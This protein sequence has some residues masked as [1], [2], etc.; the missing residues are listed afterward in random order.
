MRSGEMATEG[1]YASYWNTCLFFDFFV[2]FHIRFRFGVNGALKVGLHLTKANVKATSLL[3]GFAE[4]RMC[5][6]YCRR[7]T[8][9]KEIF[10]THKRNCETGNVFTSVSVS[11]GAG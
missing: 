11:T 6:S 10:P 7:A 3:G 5:C 8:K 4:K 9:T 1:R 2:A